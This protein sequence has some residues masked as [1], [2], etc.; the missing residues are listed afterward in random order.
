[1]AAVREAKAVFGAE[2]GLA[3]SVFP[4]KV[5]K[6]YQAMNTHDTFRNLKVMAGDVSASQSARSN[7]MPDGTDLSKLYTCFDRK[8]FTS[9]CTELLAT[10]PP[11]PRERSSSS[12]RTT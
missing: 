10:I 12:P 3:K 2:I 7:T 11:S 1:M 8:D 9:K 5:E 4:D 6:P